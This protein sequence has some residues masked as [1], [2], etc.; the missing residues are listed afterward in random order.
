MKVLKVTGVL[1]FEPYFLNVPDSYP[2]P[3][4]YTSGDHWNYPHQNDL[5]TSVL[6]RL[7]PGSL[8]TFTNSRRRGTSRRRFRYS[9]SPFFQS[10]RRTE[11]LPL[12]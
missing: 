10:S 4:R 1:F 12:Y 2:A 9:T 11:I 3:N 6:D 5:S 8:L 7:H